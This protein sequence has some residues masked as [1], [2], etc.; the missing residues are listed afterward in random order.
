MLACVPH[1]ACF[2]IPCKK[3]SPWVLSVYHSYDILA[4]FIFLY[5]TCHS[6]MYA[7][8]YFHLSARIQG[9]CRQGRFLIL[10]FSSLLFIFLFTPTPVAYGSSQARG[11]IRVAG[12]G[13]YH[14]HSNTR[15]ELHLQLTQQLAAMQDPQ[16]TEQGQR[17]NMHPHRNYLVLNSLSNNGNSFVLFLI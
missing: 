16:P 17:L 1:I 3:T 14:S 13:V 10:F 15:S 5:I 6:Y 7:R 8:V 2:L 11:R 9:W 4:C 12:P